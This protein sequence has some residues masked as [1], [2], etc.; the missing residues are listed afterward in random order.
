MR[1]LLLVAC[2]LA[3]SLSG[4]CADD[5][6]SPTLPAPKTAE[7]TTAESKLTTDPKPLDEVWEAAY[8]QDSRGVDVKI[9][10]VHLTSVPVTTDGQKLIRTTKVLRFVIG[11]AGQEAELK[12]DV[13]TDEDGAGKVHAIEARTWLAKEK[14]QTR[15][16]KIDGN[17]ITVDIGAGEQQFRWDP[18]NLG[19]AAEQTLLRDKKARPGDKFTYRYYETQITHPVTVH[20]EVKPE[21][22]IA[23]PGGVKRKLLKVIASPEPIDLPDG[24]K[25][26][27][28]SGTFWADPIGYDTVK[29]AME[30][31]GLGVVSLIRTSK[32]AA[33]AP[34]G[35]APDLMKQ[36]SIFLRAAIPDMHERDGIVYRITF[37]GNATP[38]DLVTTDE[39]QAIRNVNGN[40]FDLVMTAK[41]KPI[42][43]GTQKAGDEFLKSNYF[44]NSADP[45]VIRLA[46]QAVGTETDPWKKA[47]KVESWVRHNMR[48]AEYTE[49]MAPADHVARTLTGDCTE[50]S[51]L[52][53]AMCK[54]QG[55]PARTAIGLVYVNNLLGK[56]G[57]AFHMWTE[58]FVQGQWVAIDA[59]LGQGSIGPGHIKI[60]DHSWADVKSFTP[61]LPVQGFLMAKPTI[62]VVGR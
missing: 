42:G 11:R 14:V 10:Y 4:S 7:T 34:N 53:A 37:Q 56:P 38:K 43:E 39:R 23:L 5:R 3:F 51:M 47:Q 52:A 32:T 21:E 46:R 61:L 9:G 31:P 8:V 30:I 28:P 17:R 13:S 36:Q 26:Q 41:R 55:V 6:K 12:A 27:L 48:S 40:T 22:E 45:Q 57:L 54:A 35:Q 44:L 29:T 50:Y 58:V 19:L 24:K 16:F 15:T 20:V 33:L 49:A 25:F 59:T 60:T 62:E 1:R 2:S 18:N